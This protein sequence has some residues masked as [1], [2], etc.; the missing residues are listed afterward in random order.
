MG[1][2]ASTFGRWLPARRVAVTPA[3]ADPTVRESSRAVATTS[4]DSWR[5]GAVVV[6]FVAVA[7][8]FEDPPQP[9]RSSPATAMAAL[10]ATDLWL[11]DRTKPLEALIAGSIPRR[12]VLRNLSLTRPA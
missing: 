5:G 9:A 10:A 12:V 8:L 4:A 6:V 3:V 1:H 11:I 7:G 2:L